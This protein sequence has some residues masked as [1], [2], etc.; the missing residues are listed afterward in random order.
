MKS[1]LLVLALS[2][3]SLA[4]R[5]TPMGF[6]PRSLEPAPVQA[7]TEAASALPAGVGSVQAPEAIT[8][9]WKERMAQAY[10]FF[11]ETG[12]YRELGDSMR[13]L[14]TLVEALDIEPTGA[15]FTLFYDDPGRTPVEA[16]R[17]RVCIPVARR[18]AAAPA[19]LQFDVLERSMV[20]YTQVSGA[21]PEVPRVYPALFRFLTKMGWAPGGPIREVYLVN[22]GA[23][24][25]VDELVTEVQIPW[26]V[27]G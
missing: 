11:E 20:A 14:L 23:A 26:T 17:A 2:L 3:G 9:D 27:A 18:P 6:A 22:P 7:T 15:P 8:A 5:T 4:C 25:S 12:D 21:Y 24:S 16:L 13:R 10:V 19:A 1:S